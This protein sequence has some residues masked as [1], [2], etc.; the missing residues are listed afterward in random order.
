MT[1]NRWESEVRVGPQ[2][3]REEGRVRLVYGLSAVEE[4][5]ERRQSVRDRLR[6]AARADTPA[7]A[8]ALAWPFAAPCRCACG[9]GSALPE[10]RVGFGW[11]GYR[12]VICVHCGRDVL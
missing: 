12:P 6:L 4:R 7:A 3:V 9:G 10:Q 5:R 2:V 1:D 8:R 11:W